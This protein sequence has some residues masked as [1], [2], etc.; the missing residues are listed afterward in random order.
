MMLS[1]SSIKKYAAV[2]CC[3]YGIAIILLLSS[4]VVF[5]ADDATNYN[6]DDDDK[7]NHWA[8]IVAGSKGYDNYRH[9]ADT[10]H[11]YNIL[12]TSG[13]YSE[14]RIIHMAYDDVATDKRNPYYGQVFNRPSMFGE[15]TD[16]YA[17]CT[18]DY[19]GEDVTKE[20]LFN[21][22]K[23]EA[24]E[25][26]DK[27]LRSNHNSR[28]FFYF[29]DHGAPG[30]LQMPAPK[31]TKG[32]ENDPR[33]LFADELHDV[34]KYMHNNSLYKEMVLYIE[35]CES[36]SMFENHLED[37]M[38]IYAVTAADS[39]ESSW[40]TYCG[41]FGNWV[42]HKSIRTCLGDLF[43]VNFLENI[44]DQEEK[45][46]TSLLRPS[47]KKNKIKGEKKKKKGKETLEDQYELVKEETYPKS[48]VMQFGQMSIAKKEY[49]SDYMLLSDN[50]EEQQKENDNNNNKQNK[51]WSSLV[52][53]SSL[54]FTKENNNN[55]KLSSAVNSRDIRL[56][57]LYSNIILNPFSD[58]AYDEYNREIQERNR[59]DTIMEQIL[60]T[61]TKTN[62][63]SKTTIDFNCYRELIRAYGNSLCDDFTDYSMKYLKFFAAECSDND[64]SNNKLSLMAT[65]DRISRVC[66]Y[67]SE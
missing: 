52:M 43:S 22:L 54:L 51:W 13:G 67:S 4:S 27:V 57:N 48:T 9:Q 33:M 32:E 31:R 42:H 8:V 17:N 5:A 25:E 59:V 63:S 18:I 20:N 38:N 41:P 50:N 14:D 55:I 49:L 40:G 21:V 60:L 53:K 3:C 58:D 34:F 11:A 6:N 1:S 7:I 19:K 66:S 45:T 36:G 26:V 10:C 64:D 44:E 35:A 46:T 47:R 16:V 30:L 56:H 28:I 24:V 12:R 62:Y 39:D 2:N 65:K 37:D 23:G 29:A 15:G 61:T